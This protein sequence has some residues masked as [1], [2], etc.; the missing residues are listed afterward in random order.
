MDKLLGALVEK[1]LGGLLGVRLEI[2]ETTL[3]GTE[4]YADMKYE[5]T[6]WSALDDE[7]L[8]DSRF[9]QDKNDNKI[10]L[11]PQRIRMFRVSIKPNT[12]PRPRPPVPAPPLPVDPE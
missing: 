8:D 5:K 9:P 1:H 10:S 2:V 3:S 11:E 12:P 6:Q 7:W 4:L